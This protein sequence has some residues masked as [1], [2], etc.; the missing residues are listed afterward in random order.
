[1]SDSD[2]DMPLAK[3]NGHVS[4]ARVTEAD[5]RAMDESASNAKPAPPGI[6]IRNGP[7]VDGMDVDAPTANGSAK[8][9]SRSS[10]GKVNYRD[11]SDSDDNKPLAKRQKKTAV[12][13]SDDDD[14]PLKK[15]RKPPSYA[16]TS[17]P[18]DD[19]D[20][21]DDEP[22]ST[23]LAKK[24]A[25][26]E[27]QA[28][29]EAKAIRASESKAKKAAG[30]KPVK[31][32]SDD[33]PI[34]KTKR[35]SN[36]V[37]SA[38]KRTKVESD[39]DE[40]IAKKKKAPTKAPTK[41]PAKATPAKGKQATPAA[42]GK[43]KK[44]ESEEAEEEEE[45]DADQWWNEPKKEDGSIQWDSLEHNGVLFD[46]KYTPLPKHVKL[47]YDGKRLQLPIQ[48]E[49]AAWFF[50]SMYHSK[51]HVD[52][53]TF[54]KNYFNDFKEIIKE[55]GPVRDTDGNVVEVKDFHKIDWEPLAS[56]AE[57]QAAERRN[58]TK[59]EKKAI[60]EEKERRE[61]PFQHCLWNGRKEKVG[62]FRVEPPSLFRGRGEHPK[63]G[64]IKKQVFPEDVTINIGKGVK[65]PEPPAGHK[66]KAVVHDNKATWLASWQE[67][68]NGAYKY[69]MLAAGSSVKGK[70]DYQKFEKA[71]ELK[72]HILKIRRDYTKDL[73]SEVMAD[74]QRATAMYLIDKFAL[75]AG[76]EKNAEE[77][78]ETVGCCSLKYEHITL[79]EPN[80]VVFDFL[81]K[82]SIRFFDEFTVERQ[83]FKN[84]KLFKKPPK[85]DGDDIFD[86]LSTAQ[87]NKHLK[88]YMDGLTAK[89]FRTY[90]ASF[91]MSRLL[92]ELPVKDLTIAEKV[93]LYNDCNR[94]V[95]ILCNHKR[96]VGASHAAQMEKLGDRIKGL[97][98][99]QWRSKKM[100]LELDPKLKKK[101]GAEYF[102]LDPELDEA[103]IQ[104]HQ[105]FLVEEQRT[106]ITKKFEKD[107]DKLVA[108]GSKKMPEKELKER[109]KAADELAAKF[110][111]ENK[112]KK[113]EPEGRSPTVEKF[114]DAVKKIDER[115]NT[116]KL[117]A[118]DR[119]DNKEVA[120]GTSKINYI[121]PRL[122]VVFSRKFDV[123]I[124]KFFSKTL[125]EKFNWAIQSVKDD[126]WEF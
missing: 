70:S 97:R 117:Q 15:S 16:E 21:D 13:D 84:L 83:V 63:T 45:D 109:L 27:K 19:D 86:R 66:W 88:S 24:K 124:E 28:A 91:T 65:I 11:G 67:N 93:K 120:L 75:R 61:A 35:V 69:V 54:Q 111:K 64:K 126:K 112:T 1:M 87:L 34:A 102:E 95:A 55:H 85:T 32:E 3:S 9:K 43:V 71:R 79:K 98:Y 119:D 92:Q 107:N 42:K 57:Q 106:K 31:E 100:M 56:Y 80:T 4:A 12:E 72:K 89:V 60:K 26:I 49:E 74:R 81:G 6:S 76:N 115:I 7:V 90:N 62:N 52:N 36:G 96:T 2:D 77:E 46:Y 47:I 41:A 37:S 122:T 59:E 25:S 101:K 5:D 108:E 110:K 99:Q 103:W 116:L 114:Q 104:S 118:A 121:D 73:K 125:R 39:S 50:G 105:A 51:L 14:M 22:L 40:P 17:L 53:P 30:K 10:V 38:K 82:D 113:V 44:E 123:P 68:I 8:R 23:K 18:N 20:D 33:E 94:E 78:A 58:K 29:K 48:I